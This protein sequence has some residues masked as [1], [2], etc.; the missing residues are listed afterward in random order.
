MKYI[1]MLLFLLVF[2][3][4]LNAEQQKLRPDC[5]QCDECRDCRIR[6]SLEKRQELA[7]AEAEQRKYRLR[8]RKAKPNVIIVVRP[9]VIINRGNGMIRHHRH[10]HHHIF[11]DWGGYLRY[12]RL[13]TGIYRTRPPSYHI[14]IGRTSG[15]EPRE[16]PKPYPRVWYDGLRTRTD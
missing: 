1:A 16:R 3:L 10:F 4:T 11:N 13:Y 7:A 9:P 6:K 5:D 14:Y 8:A 12:R 15:I 2:P